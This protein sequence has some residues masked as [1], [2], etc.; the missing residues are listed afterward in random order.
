METFYQSDAGDWPEDYSDYN[1]EN[2]V[3][4]NLKAVCD[5]PVTVINEA[6]FIFSRAYETLFSI[7]TAP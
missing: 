3:P 7:S 1:F 2:E 6:I 4:A 5:F